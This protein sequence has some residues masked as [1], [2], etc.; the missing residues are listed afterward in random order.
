MEAIFEDSAG[1]LW[2]GTNDGLNLMNTER[3]SFTRYRNDPTDP[4]SLSDNYVTSIF[5]DRSGVLWVGT[6]TGGINKWN[7]RSWLFG[8]FRPETS[9]QN[10]Q[11]PKITSFTRDQNGQLWVGTFG[12]GIMILDSALELK[13]QLRAGT[14]SLSDDVVMALLTDDDGMIWAG[15]M[16]GGLNRINPLTAKVSVYRHDAKNAR[17]IPANG[18]MSLYKGADGTVWI[19][20]FGGGV[21]R[22][23]SVSDS[24]TNFPHDPAV[25]GS[26]SNPN[27]TALVEDATGALWVATSGGGLN[28][29]N[30]DQSGWDH[31]TFDPNESNSLS[32]N[33]V[34]SLHV[35]RAGNLWAGTRAGLN[36]FL[37]SVGNASAPGGFSS[38]TQADGLS[39]DVVYG[40]LSDSLGRLWLSTNYGISRFDPASGEMRNFHVSDGLQGEEFNFGAYFVDHSGTVYFGGNNGFNAFDP[41]GREVKA[42]APRVVLT[43]ISKFNQ[44]ADTGVAYEYLS[45]LSLDYVED[46][47]SFE[48]AALEYTAPSRNRYAYKLEGFDREWVQAGTTRTA[49]YTDLPGGR[50]EFLVRGANSDGVWSDEELSIAINVAHPPWLRPSAYALYFILL[51]SAIYL[52]YRFHKRKLEREAEY[53]KRL[54]LEVSDRTSDLAASNS[55]LH[56]ANDRLREASF[57]DALT[58]LHNRRYLFEEVLREDAPEYERRSKQRTGSD[59]TPNLVFIMVDLDN[60]KP[61]ND[62]CGHLAGDRVLLQVR[63][64]LHSVCRSS[65]IVIRW[66]GDEFLIVCRDPS[67]TEAS[68]LAER[69]RANI[70]DTAFSVGNGRIEHTSCSIGFAGFPFLPNAPGL[71]NW[72]QALGVADAAMYLAKEQRNAWVGIRGEQWHDSADRLYQALQAD[73]LALANSGYISIERSLSMRDAKTA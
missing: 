5:E 47:V 15:T 71:L 28:R 41:I 73:P 61:I 53:S 13:T 23:D 33:A 42:I 8:H 30:A 68:M 17:T 9:D 12:N 11:T 27:A 52:L 49:T 62:T 65:D 37:P 4:S 38:I 34:Y 16:H 63:D 24:F 20:T 67:Y 31:F 48:F 57:T 64:V 21:S 40:V 50:H 29:L 44:P 72:E 22:Y 14:N 1:R 43:G 25:P 19:G 54:E 70:A 55:E 3:D 60:F 2:V 32:S 51:V 69:L 56:D 58:G 46:M 35:D 7:A 59:S 6:K 18:I 26:L 39:N 10:S 45:G 66:G 36:R